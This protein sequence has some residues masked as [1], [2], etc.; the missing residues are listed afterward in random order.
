MADTSQLTFAT[1]GGDS[2]TVKA[3]GRH[4]VQPR[5]YAAAPGTGPAGET[6]GSCRHIWRSRRFRKCELNRA[7]WTH[8][9]RSDI[10]ARAPA[11]QRWQ[12]PE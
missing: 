2:V 10:L 5:G 9:P 8:G 3:R 4:Y 6:C 12:P 7:C 1:M 11:C